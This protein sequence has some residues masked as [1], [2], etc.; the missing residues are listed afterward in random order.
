MYDIKEAGYNEILLEYIVTKVNNPETIFE[1]LYYLFVYTEVIDMESDILVMLDSEHIDE[2]NKI[3]ILRNALI[4]KAKEVLIELGIYVNDDIDLKTITL[5]FRGLYLLENIDN[6][7]KPVLHNMLD[8]EEEDDDIDSFILILN[9][10]T[11][12]NVIDIY[13]AIEDICDRFKDSLI[14]FL[15]VEDEEDVADDDLNKITKLIHYLI[16]K[17]ENMINSLG[18][19]YLVS[20]KNIYNKFE[21]YMD[22]IRDLDINDK[23][24]FIRNVISLIVIADDSRENI[25]TTYNDYIE[26]DILGDVPLIE[27]EEYAKIFKKYHTAI[28]KNM[29][30]EKDNA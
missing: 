6:D 20:G 9:Y 21:K 23:D 1:I 11:G 10:V 13:N 14:K 7:M 24:L 25:I 22:T 26:E 5:L 3:F 29:E 4:E 16:Y 19:H 15:T 2:D 30:E 8:N 28:L 17:N 27:L 12:Q 18:V